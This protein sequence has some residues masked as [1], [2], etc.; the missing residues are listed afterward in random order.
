MLFRSNPR[1]DYSGAKGKFAKSTEIAV[2]VIEVVLLIGYA[3]PAW[4][5]RVSAFP[6]ESEAVVVRI[7]AV[8]GCGNP[9]RAGLEARVGQFTVLGIH[10]QCQLRSVGADRVDAQQR[11]PRGGTATHGRRGGCSQRRC[12]RHRGR[13]GRR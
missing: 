3:I 13:R 11:K 2:A 8:A 12:G 5:L 6:S 1:A 10:Q 4:A 7:V 9:G